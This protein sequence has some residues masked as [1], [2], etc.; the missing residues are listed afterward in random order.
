MT[1]IYFYDRDKET[2]VTTKCGGQQAII[3]QLAWLSAL[4]P[5]M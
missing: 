4:Y 3:T 2:E 1:L 5:D